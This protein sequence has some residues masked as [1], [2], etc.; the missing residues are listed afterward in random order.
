[1]L[2]QSVSWGNA[3]HVEDQPKV[4]RLA[5]CTRAPKEICEWP[6]LA[7]TLVKHRGGVL[8]TN[9]HSIPFGQDQLM[10]YH[11]SPID[12]L[13]ATNCF[14]RPVLRAATVRFR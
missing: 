13:L 5:P 9:H 2:R 3:I 4:C 1:M 10:G 7:G 8:H 14:P 6:N 11:Q 12:I